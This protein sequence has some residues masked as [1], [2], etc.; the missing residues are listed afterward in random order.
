[1]LSTDQN[2]ESRGNVKEERNASKYVVSTLSVQIS[3]GEGRRR[4]DKTETAIW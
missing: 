1:M 3:W 4:R 2:W